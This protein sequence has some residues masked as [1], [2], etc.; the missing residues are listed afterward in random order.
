MSNISQF[1]GGAPK[2]ILRGS[3][4]VISGNPIV[5]GVTPAGTVNTG[6]FVD[7]EKSSITSSYESVTNL[8]MGEARPERGGLGARFFTLVTV[9]GSGYATLVNG[10]VVVRSGRG[11]YEPQLPSGRIED[12]GNLRSEAIVYWQVVEY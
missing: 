10:E 5:T 4:A 7:P 8:A 6:I 12:I 3:T 11:L 1:Y 2:R 9:H